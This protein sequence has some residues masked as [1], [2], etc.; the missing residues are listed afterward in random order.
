MKFIL[1]GTIFLASAWFLNSCGN[2][3]N[4][5]PTV[6]KLDT[7]RYTGEW[8]E[9]ARLPNTF[10]RDLIAAKATY[11]TLPDGNLSVLNEGRKE[12]GE[13]TSIHG[14]ARSAGGPGKL[15]VR[16]DPFPANLFAGDYWILDVNPSYTRALVGSPD[17][18]FLWLLSK[19]P[20]DR[21]ED[22]ASQISKA[23]DLG[24]E[25]EDL[26]FNPARIQPGT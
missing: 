15:E 25:T 23:R 2:K 4:P 12:N 24:F 9:I 21:K 19:D 13:Q 1:A 3:K 5:P 11:G 6:T 7:S 26:Y 8:H 10:E 22:F 17:K 20:G 18:N 16:F 14:T